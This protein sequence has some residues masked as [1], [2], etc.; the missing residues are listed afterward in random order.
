MTSLGTGNTVYVVGEL[1]PA[2]FE[3]ALPALIQWLNSV[4]GPGLTA[5][6]ERPQIVKLPFEN[7]KCDQQGANGR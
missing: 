1:D 7:E 2:V 4:P 5:P 3:A 6:A